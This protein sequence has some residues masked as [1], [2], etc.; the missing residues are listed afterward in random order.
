MTVG[1]SSD[2]PEVDEAIPQ[3]EHGQL[4]PARAQRASD[5]PVEDLVVADGT[6]PSDDRRAVLARRLAKTLSVATRILRWPSLVLIV[7]PVLPLVVIAWFATTATR[8][9]DILVLWVL[10]AVGLGIEVVF[11]WRRR[12]FLDA[13]KDPAGMARELRLLLSPNVV[14]DE[15]MALL[16]QVAA[17]GGLLIFRRLWAVWKLANL[18][19]HLLDQ[20]DDYPRAKLYLPPS[21]GISGIVS[22]CQV[23]LTILAWPVLL[24]VITFRLTG[25]F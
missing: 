14:T 17:R 18:P 11:I 3:D 19:E 1:A 15:V 16:K 7:I 9:T 4:G 24:V 21:I 10:A 23:W 8:W 5:D 12:R 6:D 20:L 22:L 2:P 25:V 13:A